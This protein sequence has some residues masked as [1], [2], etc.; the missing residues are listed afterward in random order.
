MGKII[1]WFVGRDAPKMDTDLSGGYTTPRNSDGVPDDFGGDSLGFHLLSQQ[2]SAGL[3][4]FAFGLF[5]TRNNAVVY[6]ALHR[7]VQ[8]V[9]CAIA[10]LICNSGLRVVTRDG[11]RVD[12]RRTKYL[13]DVMCET[14]DDG[15][16]PSYTFFTD[17]GADYLL[18]GNGLMVP[19]FGSTGLFKGARRFEPWTATTTSDRI[20]HMIAA[21]SDDQGA[22]YFAKRDVVHVRWPLMQ[23]NNYTGRRGFALSPI[24][25]LRTA[26]QVGLGSDRYVLDW[27]G[28]GTKTRTHLD[29]EVGEDKAFKSHP[30]AEQKREIHKWVRAQTQ[31]A[32][33]LVTFGAKSQKIDETPQDR[34]MQF[35]RDFQ[36]QEVA[37][38]FGVP[39]PLL[40][41]NI[42][43]WGASVNEQIAKLG[44][45]WGVKLHMD[46]M[47]AAI[48]LRLL[49]RG[50]RFQP[51][52][53]MLTQGDAEAITELI[54]ALRGDAQGGPV[55]TGPELR[56]MA[57]L[58]IE[59]EGEYI[60]M[61]MS[62]QQTSEGNEA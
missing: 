38:F 25:L 4:S 19:E 60:P 11:H 23:G 6:A 28:G 58:P 7:C 45:R 27:Y 57:Q 53:M 2:F 54:R 17:L 48:G 12:N 40:S 34:Q 59:P 55:A 10:G 44:Y 36:V 31:N 32:G 22:E 18:D 56:R 51:D 20:Y 14:M 47:L 33:P 37:R 8:L 16:T 35:L 13:L 41:V 49:Q 46:G 62:T 61:P 42:Q 43:Q 29:Y 9:T 5:P 30:T 1:D 50:E 24:S 21:G 15:D 52:P 3:P 39:L 26:I